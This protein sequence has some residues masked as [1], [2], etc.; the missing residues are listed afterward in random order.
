MKTSICS[1]FKEN[2]LLY[3]R[4]LS[5]FAI[6][7]TIILTARSVS[8]VAALVIE[9]ANFVTASLVFQ[10]RPLNS[11]HSISY[12]KASSLLFLVVLDLDPIF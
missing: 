10:N 5:L 6:A 1:T 11:T 12:I 3:F 2:L 4:K 8:Q 7:V 9:I